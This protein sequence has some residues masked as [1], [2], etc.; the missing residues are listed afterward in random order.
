MA[1]TK[2]QI[3]KANDLKTIEIDVPEW[4]GSVKVQ[5]MTGSARQQF[6]E[7]L[8]VPKGKLPKNMMEALLVATL[9]DDKGGPLFSADDVAELAKKSS[10]AIQRVWEVA[11]DLNGLTDKSVKA[12]EKN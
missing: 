3:L 8:N 6:Q 4:G 2:E 10:L 12:L 1:L 5:T 7:A 11:A 9:I